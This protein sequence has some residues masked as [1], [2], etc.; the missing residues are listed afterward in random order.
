MITTAR[1][2]TIALGL[3][4]VAALAFAGTGAATQPFGQAPPFL[5]KRGGS[6]TVTLGATVA[7]SPEDESLPPLG[8]AHPHSGPQARYR[9]SANR[10]TF[11]VLDTSQLQSVFD[12]AAPATNGKLHISSIRADRKAPVRTPAATVPHRKNIARSVDP[13]APS[14]VLALKAR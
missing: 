4:A 13:K 8:S 9:S 2:R 10:P 11:C 3:T 7:Q 5:T 14:P 12:N 6:N 1:T